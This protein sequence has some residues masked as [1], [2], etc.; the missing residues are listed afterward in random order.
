MEGAHQVFARRKIH[1]RLA[2]HGRI[3]GGQQG[4]GNLHIGDAAH[5]SRR[6][7]P[8]H[9]PRHAAAQG[10]DERFAVQLMPG[11]KFQNIGVSRKRFAGFACREHI[12]AGRKPRFLQGREKRICIKRVYRAL[13]DDGDAAGREF[14]GDARAR[15]AQQARP[16]QNLIALSEGN[17][18]ISHNLST[19]SLSSL[20]S[21]KSCLSVSAS[22]ALSAALYSRSR[23][24]MQSISSARFSLFSRK[25]SV[26]MVSFR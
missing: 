7:K 2:A 5:I 17:M 25:S 18:H 20:P 9:I 6:G 13:C 21:F 11:E 15:L 19:F 14:F 8:G 3:D 12:F 26:H 10:D 23:S 1:R 4:G 22:S 16:D 24:A